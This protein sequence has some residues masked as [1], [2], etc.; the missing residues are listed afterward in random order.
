M[1]GGYGDDLQQQHYQQL[2]GGGGGD[3]GRVL[4]SCC[5]GES[6]TPKAGF[7]QLTRRLR[8]LYRPER[9]DSPD[10]LN[11]E[12]LSTASI[13]IFGCPHERFTAS[14]FNVGFGLCGGL[15]WM[16]YGCGVI[17][18]TGMRD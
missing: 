3:I 15:M 14:Q 9:L 6:H 5:K 10:E 16:L 4:F 8:T 13:V 17:S 2:N 18:Q 1:Q 7:K 11:L 12:N